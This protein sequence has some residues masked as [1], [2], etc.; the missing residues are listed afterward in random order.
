MFSGL[1]QFLIKTH[2]PIKFAHVAF[3][4]KH[5]VFLFDDFKPI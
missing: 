2:K 5:S 4:S 3:V 1:N